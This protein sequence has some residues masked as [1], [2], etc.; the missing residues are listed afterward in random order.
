[1]RMIVW[2]IEKDPPRYET[3]TDGKTCNRKRD[4]WRD[5]IGD[6]SVKE[7]RRLREE[8]RGTERD[9]EKKREKR[10]RARDKTADDGHCR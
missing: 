3:R 5:M 7:T 8:R 2:L 6:K 1:M 10:H 4:I 9:R